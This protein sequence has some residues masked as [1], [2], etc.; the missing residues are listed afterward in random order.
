MYDD[1]LQ[2]GDAYWP[3]AASCSANSAPESVVHSY[4]TTES[5][6]LDNGESLGL[7]NYELERYMSKDYLR[8]LHSVLLFY[9]LTSRVDSWNN[10]SCQCVHPPGREIQW[11]KIVGNSL[12]LCRLKNIE[13]ATPRSKHR[14]DE[15]NIAYF[16]WVRRGLWPPQRDTIPKVAE[17]ILICARCFTHR[18]TKLAYS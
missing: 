4:W 12:T 6:R 18:K 7:V 3:T 9:R 11:H 2:V 10:T 1:Q 5:I 13:Q 16:H 8:H 14:I 15:T 17:R